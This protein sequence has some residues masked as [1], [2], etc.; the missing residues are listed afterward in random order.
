MNEKWKIGIDTHLSLEM[1]ENFCNP[2]IFGQRRRSDCKHRLG[3]DVISDGGGRYTQQF[4]F[5][6]EFCDGLIPIQEKIQFS[7]GNI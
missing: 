6:E 1:L 2:V 3:I 7:S 4:I 5:K